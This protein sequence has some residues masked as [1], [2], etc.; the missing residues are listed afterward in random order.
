MKTLLLCPALFDSHGGI[1]RI[2]RLYLKALCELAGPSDRV[3][4]A[5]LNDA[6]L[7]PAQ[8]SPF[9]T[10]ALGP[11][12][13]GGRR[14]LA[15]AL[16]TVLLARGADRLVCGHVNLLPIVR[17]ARLVARRMATVLV[18]HGTEVWRPFSAAERAALRRLGIVLC[19]SEYTRRTLHE[20]C[21]D[22]EPRRIR[23]QFNA[24]DPSFSVPPRPDAPAP[25]DT[26]LTVSRLALADAYKGIDDLIRALPAIRR[27]VPAARLRVVGDGDDRARL[28]ALAASEGVADHIDFA[29][30]LDDTALREAFAQCRVF[31]LPSRREGFGLVFLEAMAHGKPCVAVAAGAAPE[32][33]DADSG[34][35]ARPGDVAH[36]AETCVAA[37]RRTWDATAIRSRADRFSYP[38]FKDSLASALAA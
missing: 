32:V 21:P 3:A 17:A 28:A 31:A 11:V 15:F 18:A 29:G 4:L 13:A 38:R 6:A 37:L 8:L 33:V 14:K 10:P 25:S 5:V 30:R 36:L 26:L 16:R 35:I 1:E 12:V 24:L 27:A 2:L 9:A 22:L 23:V 34:L 20:H 7:S 19:V